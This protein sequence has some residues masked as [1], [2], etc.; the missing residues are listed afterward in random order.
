MRV[1]TVFQ[2]TISTDTW[3]PIALQLHIEQ[4]SK[5]NV[6]INGSR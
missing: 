1:F 6:Q 3:K 4:R 5:T 2:Q